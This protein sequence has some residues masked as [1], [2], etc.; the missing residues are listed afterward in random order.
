MATIFK[1]K[2]SPCWQ[3]SYFHNGKRVTKS[4]GVK[5]RSLAISE[6]KKLEGKIADGT[7]EEFEKAGLIGLVDL[8]M[9]SK[10]E[11]KAHTTNNEFA[12]LDSFVKQTNK[13]SV[14]AITEAD[15]LSYMEPYR[16]KSPYTFRNSLAA[17][18]RLFAFAVKKKMLPAHKNPTADVE[19]RRITKKQPTYLTDAE[20]LSIERAASGDPIYPLIVVAR[21]T[22]LRLAELLHLEWEDF[23][24]S[25]R[26]LEVKNKPQ[27][28]HTIKNH[29]GRNVPITEELVLKL[30][31]Y[32][33]D[34]GLCFPSPRGGVYAKGGPKKALLGVFVAAGIKDKKL[35]GK[36]E[37]F[38]TF[39]RTFASRLVQ[40]GADIVRVSKWLGHS[41][42]AVTEKHYACFKPRYHADIERLNIGTADIIADIAS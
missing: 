24:W 19:F 2:G 10:S 16:K 40:N 18:K 33:K 35:K 1:R 27:F 9:K 32:R 7:H 30:L 15:I 21:Y 41:S 34:F 22:G 39:R 14:D 13:R 31:P 37:G 38:H 3:I 5:D 12:V 36:G 26:E 17:L 23:D 4:L 11:L 8:Y 6:R 42:I 28:N 29:E 25:K 20:Y